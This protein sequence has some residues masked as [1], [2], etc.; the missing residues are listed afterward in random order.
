MTTLRTTSRRRSPLS[1]AA[2]LTASAVLLAGCAAAAADAPT[3]EEP[4]AET[5]TIT[6]E[7]GREVELDIPITAVYGDLWYQSEII[8]GIGAGDT[9]VAIESSSDPVA[10][11][12]NAE[13]FAAFEGLPVV[14]HYEEPNWE[15]IVESGAEVALMRRNGPWEE[16]VEKLEPFGIDVVVVTTWDPIVLREYLPLLGEIFGAEEGAAELAALYDDIEDILAE[17]LDEATVKSVYFE[18]NA[19]FVTSVPGSGWH[20]TIVLGGGENLFGDVNVGNDSSASVHQYEVDPVEV[21][22]RNPDVIIHTGIDGGVSG[23]EPWTRDELT[24]QTEAIADR[25]GWQATTAVADE[26]VYVFNNF[27]YSALGKQLGALAVATWLYPD[28]FE[29]VDIDDY[30]ARWLT[31]QGVEPRPVSDYVHKLGQ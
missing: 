11:P 12:L 17:R 21:I 18:N 13:Y 20:D 9:I 3:A 16:A 15:A 23:Y 24:A 7:L 8:R 27:F 28:R 2:V 25:P 6:D 14:G 4:A 26:E 22:A 31:S 5:V 29:D 30:F 1:A 10:N 19:D